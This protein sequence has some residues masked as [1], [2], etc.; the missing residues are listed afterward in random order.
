[1]IVSAVVM[2][3]ASTF[4][5]FDTVTASPTVWSTRPRLTSVAACR[6]RLLTP[7][8]PSIENSAQRNA[9]PADQSVARQRIADREVGVGRQ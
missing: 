7:V 1:M 4:W 6:T 9:A 5:K 2:N 8:P 3:V